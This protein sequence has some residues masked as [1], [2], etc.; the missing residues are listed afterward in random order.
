MLVLFLTLMQKA[1]LVLMMLLVTVSSL[2][3][4]LVLIPAYRQTEEEHIA[5]GEV[6]SKTFDGDLPRFEACNYAFHVPTD[7]CCMTGSD[8]LFI[9]DKGS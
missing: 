3:F 6:H 8:Y 9:A 2:T 7:M 4:A 5:K 1:V